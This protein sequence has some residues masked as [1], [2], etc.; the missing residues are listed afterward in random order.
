M[1]NSYLM[2]VFARALT[3]PIA[4]RANGDGTLLSLQGVLGRHT[5]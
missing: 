5:L 2:L 3:P 1:K 4:D